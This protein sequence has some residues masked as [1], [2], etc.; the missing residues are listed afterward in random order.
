MNRI[1]LKHN[2]VK[3][4]GPLTLYPLCPM[5]PAQ[6]NIFI[7]SSLPFLCSPSETTPLL[8][9]DIAETKKKTMIFKVCTD[10]LSDW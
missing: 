6:S 8:P 7:T 1:A 3:E 2:F 4:F 5:Y 9:V 10:T